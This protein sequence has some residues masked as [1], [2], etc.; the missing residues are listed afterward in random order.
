MKRSRINR[1]IG[2]TIAFLKDRKFLLPPFAYWTP[3]QWRR[4]GH[5]ADEIRDCML[6]WDV[7]DLGQ[8]DFD[9]LGLALFTIRNG[10]MKSRKYPKPY[11][12]KIIVMD[13][14]QLCP[15]HFHWQKAEDIINRGGGNCVLRLWNSTPRGGLA[16]TPVRVTMDGVVRTF[17]PG[18]RVVMKPGESITL[19]QGLYHNFT[20]E[21]G[22]LLLGEVSTVNDDTTDNRFHE[23]LG[24]FPK[25]EEDEEPKFLL[26]SEY[27]RAK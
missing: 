3:A 23:P 21:G 22:K 12:E 19:T 11:C 25:V 27:P 9:R 18:Q 20:A 2:E 17:K 14:G 5:E 10:K 6:G 26:C 4:M 24:R 8:G 13:P 16:K 7:T 15:T 1:A